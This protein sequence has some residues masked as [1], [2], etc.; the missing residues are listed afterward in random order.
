MK[1]L[2]V[3]DRVTLPHFKF[4]SDGVIT[5]VVKSRLLPNAS[6]Y[7]IKLDEKAPNEYAYD[8]YNVFMFPRDVE[9]VE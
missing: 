7:V 8:T 5:E 3:G 2:K 6:G 9:L 1:Q 4:L